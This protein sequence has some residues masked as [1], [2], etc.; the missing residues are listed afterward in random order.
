MNVLQ[1]VEAVPWW[2]PVQKAYW[3]QPMGPGS[4]VF[5]VNEQT[6]KDRA[7]YPVVRN[8]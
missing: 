5:A 2:L 7:D 4:D 8:S 3:Y 6:G 1:A